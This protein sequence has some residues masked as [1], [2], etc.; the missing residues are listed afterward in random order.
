MPEHDPDSSVEKLLKR[1]DEPP[2]IDPKARARIL[3]HLQGQYAT[4]EDNAVSAQLP[5]ATAEQDAEQRT[6]PGASQNSEKTD[7]IVN[8]IMGTSAEQK[9]EHN[10]EQ[11]TDKSADKNANKHAPRS[12]HN[13]PPGQNVARRRWSPVGLGLAFAACLALLWGIPRLMRT[14]DAH[15]PGDSIAR[16]SNDGARPLAITLADG[17]VAW[18]RSGATLE[19]LDTRRVHLEG[20][21]LLRVVDNREPFTVETQHGNAIATGEVLFKVGSKSTV[22]AVARGHARLVGDDKAELRTGETVTLRGTETPTIRAARRLTHLL[23]WAEPL[24]KDTKL[25][26]GPARRGNLLARDPAT[27]AWATSEW[28]LPMRKLDVDVVIE[29]GVARTTIDQT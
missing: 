16:H 10:A 24:Y 11:N 17:S 8:T 27:M 12:A 5:N 29:N 3:A 14:P 7:R 18:L 2:M 22:I 25:A 19:V 4:R 26:S 1:A 28:P 9:G 23:A 15:A 13:D 21:A 6:D 20:E